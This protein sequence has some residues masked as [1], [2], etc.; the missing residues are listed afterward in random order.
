MKHH[1]RNSFKEDRGQN[2]I[3]INTALTK[4]EVRRRHTASW[5]TFV[6]NLEYVTYWTQRKV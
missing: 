3:K 6:T 2:R 4:T 1:I 5:D